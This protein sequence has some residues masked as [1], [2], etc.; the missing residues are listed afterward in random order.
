MIHRVILTFHIFLFHIML[1]KLQASSSSSHTKN[2]CPHISTLIHTD[3]HRFTQRS[4]CIQ[5]SLVHTTACPHDCICLYLRRHVT[6]YI[7]EE[8]F[9]VTSQL[10]FGSEPSRLAVGDLRQAAARSYKPKRRYE[11]SRRQ[12]EPSRRAIRAESSAVRAESSAIRAES[13]AI[14]ADS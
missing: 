14:R 5:T 13:S 12:F 2:V 11:L 3:P 9:I 6:Y 10:N 1:A 4:R 8:G 7:R